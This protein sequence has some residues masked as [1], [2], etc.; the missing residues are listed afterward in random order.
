[1]PP[2]PDSKTGVAAPCPTCAALGEHRYA[3]FDQDMHLPDAAGALEVLISLNYDDDIRRCRTCGT[4]YKFSFKTDNDIFQ[5]THT[6]EYDRIPASKAEAMIR[7]ERERIESS[8]KDYRK[9][10]RRVHKPVM[11]SLSPVETR[12]LDHLIKQYCE[13]Y[14]GMHFTT[15]AELIEA[16]GIDASVVDDAIAHLRELQVVEASSY[17]P[18]ACR[19]KTYRI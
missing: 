10:M 9:K 13:S 2:R 3:D 16:L 18:D 15:K 6:G 12:I 8:I 19:I 7:E 1:M 14:L 5:P 17:S 4:Y 11:A